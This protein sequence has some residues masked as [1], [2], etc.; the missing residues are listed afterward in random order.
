MQVAQDIL[1]NRLVVA[2]EISKITSTMV[3]KNRSYYKVWISP[4]LCAFVQGGSL[5]TSP[6]PCSQMIDEAGGF[7]RLD[8]SNAPKFEIVD[9]DD[10]KNADIRAAAE[11]KQPMPPAASSTSEPE[12]SAKKEEEAL[13][14]EAL[15]EGSAT[16]ESTADSEEGGADW[17]SSD[18]TEF[19][20]NGPIMM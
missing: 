18:S 4:L 11:G 14:D 20:R 9:L 1:L 16:S 17:T 8:L 15:H 12:S 6:V 7:R 5:H 10:P 3:Q 2:D 19:G 13:A